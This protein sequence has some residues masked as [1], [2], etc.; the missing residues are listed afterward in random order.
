MLVEEELSA[1]VLDPVVP[2]AV[3]LLEDASVVT[4]PVEATAVL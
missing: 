1:A 4:A 2:T 3:V